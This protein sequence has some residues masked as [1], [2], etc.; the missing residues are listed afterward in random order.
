MPYTFQETTQNLQVNSNYFSNHLWLYHFIVCV[1][2][3]LLGAYQLL[4]EKGNL[5]H[6]NLN[7]FYIIGYAFTGATVY[8][9]FSK[10]HDFC[11]LFNQLL[12]L[13]DTNA[14]MESPSEYKILSQGC[15]FVIQSYVGIAAL[16]SFTCAW[17]P[18]SDWRVLPLNLINL[19]DYN[20]LVSGLFG[21][22]SSGFL[23]YTAWGTYSIFAILNVNLGILI[24]TFCLSNAVKN[25]NRWVKQA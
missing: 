18:K 6:T 3:S 1:S 20:S 15:Q 16:F 14:E 23:N 25:F 17:N 11:K 2:V 22:V 19:W 9:H 24:P 13:M 12:D 21:R 7:T 4:H 5:L 10:S 8:T